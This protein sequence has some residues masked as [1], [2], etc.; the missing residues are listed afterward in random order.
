MSQGIATAMPISG[1]REILLRRDHPNRI[2]RKRMAVGFSTTP[3]VG[4]KQQGSI[5]AV[6][7]KL[8]NG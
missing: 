8:A 1:K 3:A 4:R 6:E 2:V 5:D 7:Q